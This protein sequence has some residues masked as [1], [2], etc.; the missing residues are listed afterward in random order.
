MEYPSAILNLTCKGSVDTS[1]FHWWFRAERNSI[2]RANKTGSTATNIPA[3][4]RLRTHDL[5]Y[6]GA[7]PY[8]VDHQSSFHL[9]FCV[10]FPR[11]LRALSTSVFPMRFRLFLVHCLTAA[12]SILWWLGF[13]WLRPI[14]FSAREVMT[15]G[16]TAEC[17]LRTPGFDR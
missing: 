5:W 4:S 9:W 17:R 2:L 7:Y 8:L 3:N 16:S 12:V 13:P 1:P 14:F 11:C 10:I 6:R 15:P